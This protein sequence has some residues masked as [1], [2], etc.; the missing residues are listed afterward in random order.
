MGRK[1]TI[2]MCRNIGLAAALLV[3]GAVPAIAQEPVALTATPCRPM[4]QVDWTAP[5][6][7]QFGIAL[8]CLEQEDYGGAI[9]FHAVAAAMM[10]FDAMRVGDPAARSVHAEVAKAFG[11]QA[12][13]QAMTAQSGFLR[14]MDKAAF[15]AEVCKL[16]EEKGPPQ[17]AVTYM[18]GRGEAGVDILRPGFDPAAAWTEVSALMMRCLPGG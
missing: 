7:A 10:F 16:F 12:G 4:A 15:S 6:P 13:E 3:L 9:R 8:G 11:D 1:G 2:G 17:H 18:E 14:T 5:P